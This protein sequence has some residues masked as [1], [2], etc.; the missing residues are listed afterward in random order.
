MPIFLFFKLDPHIV[1][2]YQAK[3]NNYNLLDRYA[4]S[5]QDNKATSDYSSIDPEHYS[6][7][8]RQHTEDS[9]KDALSDLETVNLHVLNSQLLDR[10]YYL[11]IVANSLKSFRITYS[12]LNVVANREESNVNQADI[13]TLAE[14][15]FDRNKYFILTVCL[16]VIALVLFI[17]LSICYCCTQFIKQ[18]SQFKKQATKQDEQNSKMNSIIEKTMNSMKKVR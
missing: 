4:L 14:N 9:N 15:F 8:R 7:E 3:D 6:I 1:T 10:A 2:E 16:C 12:F 11:C 5:L 17:V 13:T 18:K